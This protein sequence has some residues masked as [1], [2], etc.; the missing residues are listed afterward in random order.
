MRSLFQAFTIAA[1]SLENA[2]HFKEA[3]HLYAYTLSQFPASKA[4]IIPKYVNVLLRLGVYEATN[5]R[6]ESYLSTPRYM[7]NLT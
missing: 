3:L 7:I 4:D 1:V 6:L 2:G 5:G